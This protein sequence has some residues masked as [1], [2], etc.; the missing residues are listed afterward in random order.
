M[1]CG[2]IRQLDIMDE[3]FTVV[4]SGN[5]FK[6]SPDIQQV[7]SEVVLELAPGARFLHITAP[8]V[9]CS[10]MLAMEQVSADYVTVRQRIIATGEKMLVGSQANP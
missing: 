8:P 1:A 9:T 4:L 3:E 2:I 5:L 7:L 10:V 6:G